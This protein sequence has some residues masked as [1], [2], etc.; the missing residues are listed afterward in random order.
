MWGIFKKHHLRKRC[1]LRTGHDDIP[2]SVCKQLEVRDAYEGDT[3]LSEA[4]FVV[5]DTETTGLNLDKGDRLLSLGAVKIT[6]GKIHLGEAF[7]ELIDPE[8]PIPSSSIFIHGITPGMAKARPHVSEVLSR[9]LTFVG[10]HVLVAHHAPFDMRF[11]NHAME[12]CFGFPFQ[13]IVIDTASVAAWIRRLQEVEIMDR[14]TPAD[15]RFDA[16]AA[17]FGIT[18][19]DRHSAFGDALSTA[20]LFQRFINILSDNGVTTLKQLVKIAGRA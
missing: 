16:V 12:G 11:L 15:T 4:G 8:R 3:A 18:A 10:S 20:L 2:E 17:H 5:F 7:Y 6:G 19:Q 14:G 9:F 13:N 1:G